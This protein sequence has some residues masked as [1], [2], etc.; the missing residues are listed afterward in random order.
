[1]PVGI[2]IFINRL[3]PAKSVFAPDQNPA[4]QKPITPRGDSKDWKNCTDLIEDWLEIGHSLETN[5]IKNPFKIEKL[6]FCLFWHKKC[7]NNSG[8]LCIFVLVQENSIN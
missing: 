3:N 6:D 2:Y 8:S 7:F 5:V 4:P 1:M